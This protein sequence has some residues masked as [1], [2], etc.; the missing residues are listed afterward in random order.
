MKLGRISSVDRNG[1]ILLW[2]LNAYLPA[3]YGVVE[4]NLCDIDVKLFRDVKDS[5]TWNIHRNVDDLRIKNT[6]VRRTKTNTVLWLT[7][8][9]SY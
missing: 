7:L 8:G 1:F 5:M 4:V 3:I 9:D 2:G 6:T